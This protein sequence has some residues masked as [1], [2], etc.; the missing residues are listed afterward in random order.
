LSRSRVN[1]QERAEERFDEIF[2]AEIPLV[3]FALNRFYK[4][5]T[6]ELAFVY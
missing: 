1:R 5:L 6:D 2:K 4:I 3:L